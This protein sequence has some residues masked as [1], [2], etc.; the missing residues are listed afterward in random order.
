MRGANS[1]TFQHYM[2]RLRFD[3]K[4]FANFLSTDHSQTGAFRIDQ[5]ID[6]T[7]GVQNDIEGF[8]IYAQ[9][10]GVVIYRT[11]PGDPSASAGHF[12]VILYDCGRTARYLHLQTHSNRTVGT[13]VTPSMS[14]GI[15]GR[16][17]TAVSHLHFDVN[18][19]GRWCGLDI[20]NN[21]D[22]VIRATSVFPTETFRR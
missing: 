13:R 17:G 10:P 12:V 11:E 3:G 7:N 1:T 20:A 6:I 16:T 19:G 15:T 8:V 5:G 18:T 21:P 9:G 2:Y 14:I 22:D 4:P